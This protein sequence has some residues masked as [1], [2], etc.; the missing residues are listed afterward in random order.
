MT[1]VGLV[2]F[3]DAS[4]GSSRVM[5]DD[6]DDENVAECLLPNSLAARLE[7]C[8]DELEQTA[9]LVSSLEASASLSSVTCELKRIISELERRP[10]RQARK[11]VSRLV[12]GGLRRLPV[13]REKTFCAVVTDHD[14][15]ETDESE[16][17]SAPTTRKKQ[18][19]I[20]IHPNSLFK[21]RWDFATS[22]FSVVLVFGPEAHSAFAAAVGRARGLRRLFG[23]LALEACDAV[24]PK[25][26]AMLNAWFVADI[27]LN[28]VTG[29]VDRKGVLVMKKRR[30]A[31]NYFTTFFAL[32]LWCA[33]PHRAVAQLSQTHAAPAGC[34]TSFAYCPPPKR[35]P[36]R[37]LVSVWRRA[38]FVVPN[39]L[40][41]AKR[42]G[43]LRQVL[44]SGPSLTAFVVRLIRAIRTSSLFRL[45]WKNA[46]VL[47]RRACL[48]AARLLTKTSP[49]KR[50]RSSSSTS[51]G[52]ASSPTTRLPPCSPRPASKPRFYHKLHRHPKRKTIALAG[53]GSR[54]YVSGDDPLLA[55]TKSR[56]AQ[57]GGVDDS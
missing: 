6:D 18:S 45:K 25:L 3:G 40:A 43:R 36:L 32:D 47:A 57:N 41:F 53:S 29:Y 19:S 50:F 22:V 7:K 16:S 54:S 56:T 35:G 27:L 34:E 4:S 44:V 39:T 2:Y 26:E 37:M 55:A 48:F 1:L 12:A 33:L 21:R 11:A 20:A 9:P 42:R 24:L 14:C 51:K 52:G 38:K 17:E 5:A 10:G 46:A 31:L 30:I 15:W 23:E 28:F 8:A 49:P 13:R